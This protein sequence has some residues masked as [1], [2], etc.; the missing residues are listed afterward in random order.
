MAW[1][2]VAGHGSGSLDDADL[3]Y[4]RII[5][6]QNTHCLVNKT[7]QDASPNLFG[8]PERVASQ[9]NTEKQLQLLI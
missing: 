4:H 6:H 1:P 5:I 3:S 2:H 9:K 8:E 7:L